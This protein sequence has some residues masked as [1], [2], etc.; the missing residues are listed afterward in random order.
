MDGQTDKLT[1]GWIGGQRMNRLT[2][3]MID[4]WTWTNTD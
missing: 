2:K 1:D 3:V 4:G